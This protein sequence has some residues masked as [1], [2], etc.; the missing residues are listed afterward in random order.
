MGKGISY[1][2]EASVTLKETDLVQASFDFTISAG[3]QKNVTGSIKEALAKALGVDVKQLL[4]V[5]VIFLGRRLSGR[6]L[7]ESKN[8]RVDYTL[9]VPVAESVENLVRRAKSVTT[10]GVFQEAMKDSGLTVAELKTVIAPFVFKQATVANPAD[11]P[12]GEVDARTQ[13][14]TT[15]SE[16]EA[17]AAMRSPALIT[18]VF[19]LQISA[20]VMRHVL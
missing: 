10:G 14:A 1:C 19:L 17:D 11:N 5:S 20:G 6:S 4:Q 15:T 18:R 3:E 8:V 16:D 9:A 7:E 12:L 2:I 13:A